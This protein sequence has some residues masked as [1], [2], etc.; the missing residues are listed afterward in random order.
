KGQQVLSGHVHAKRSDTES[1][2]HSV[3]RNAIAKLDDLEAQVVA[4]LEIEGR[5]AA[6]VPIRIRDREARIVVRRTLPGPPIQHCCRVVRVGDVETTQAL[7]D[8]VS[9]C[10]VGK[11]HQV[12]ILVS[13][14]QG[15]T[16][17]VFRKARSKERAVKVVGSDNTVTI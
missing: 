10:T 3:F 7:E 2:K 9:T 14:I 11:H 13:E 8:L 17:G 5:H 1:L 6:K 4:V 15:D 12:E 16:K